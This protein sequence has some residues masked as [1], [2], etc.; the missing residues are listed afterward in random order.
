MI[1]TLVERLPIMICPKWVNVQAQPI[2]IEDVLAYLTKA[3]D[4]PESDSIV[5]EIGGPDQISYG[6][7]MQR[8][9]SQRGF[10]ALDDSC[11]VLNSL[12]FQLVAGFDH[13]TLFSCRTKNSLIV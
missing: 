3:L 11:S 4:L 8:Y 10:E 5:F 6:E 2:A 9:A 1:R 7:I 12:S 13:T